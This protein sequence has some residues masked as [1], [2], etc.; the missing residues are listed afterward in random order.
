M[1]HPVDVARHGRSNRSAEHA[2][3]D[4][5]QSVAP[6]EADRPVTG[7]ERQEAALA[8]F[9]RRL[10]EVGNRERD[11]I[12]RGHLW[13]AH[14]WPAEYAERCITVGGRP[15]CRRCATL[16]PLGL[17][18]AFLF[19]TSVIPWPAGIDP[20]AIWLLSIPATIAYCGEA[21]G[22]FGYRPSIQVATTLLAAVA[23]GRGLSYEL[24]TRWSTEFWGPIAVF[25][26]IWFLATAI[27]RAR[28]KVQMRP[29]RVA[30]YADEGPAQ[31]R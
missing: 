17:T 30:G 1:A 2:G 11:R 27:G 16:Y 10:V 22:L 14:H 19:A 12:G 9:E 15:V 8:L 28:A 23:F 5:A 25:G 21:I 24:L 20:A 4:Q 31:T 6:A 29:V 26:G 13:L 18:L 7:D 3:G